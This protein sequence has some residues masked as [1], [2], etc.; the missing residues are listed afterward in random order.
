MLGSLRGAADVCLMCL[1][2]KRADI[3]SSMAAD[4][5]GESVQVPTGGRYLG[6]N[7]TSAVEAA[8]LAF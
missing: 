6:G 5:A 3:R 1:R 4:D 2:L 8:L 7:K